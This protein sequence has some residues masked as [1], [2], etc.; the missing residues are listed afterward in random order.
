[1][2]SRIFH[3]A[4]TANNGLVLLSGFV[5]VTANGGIGSSAA[6]GTSEGRGV[7][8]S[9]TSDGVYVFTLDDKYV[10]IQSV[11]VTLEKSALTDVTWQCSA[12][13]PSTKKATVKFLSG[14]AERRVSCHI[15]SATAAN[16]TTGATLFINNRATATVQVARVVFNRT[17]ASNA[18]ARIVRFQILDAA[19]AVTATCANV[20][21]VATTFTAWT[22]KSLALTA[23][24][25]VGTGYS[26]RVY[27]LKAGSGVDTPAGTAHVRY[28]DVAPLALATAKIHY[29]IVCRNSTVQ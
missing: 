9:K 6:T 4:R 22:P 3:S 23:N 27:L 11:N 20:S 2:A 16:V 14:D 17:V 28:T 29:L 13:V 19:G 26:L 15:P 8:C 7:S 18:N 12:R 24:V 5:T 21:S 10:E 25:A 1:M